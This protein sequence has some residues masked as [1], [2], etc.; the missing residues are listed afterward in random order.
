MKVSTDF[1]SICSQVS[2]HIAAANPISLNI[3]SVDQA[4][5]AREKA[6]YEEQS[7]SSGKPAQVIEKMVEGKIKKF[8]EENVLLEQTLVT[9]GKTKVLDLIATFNKANS[10]N[11]KLIS[12]GRFVL[13][14]NIKQ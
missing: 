10:A 4:L 13:G 14:Q 11:V 5:L 12:F 1:K 6:I 3:E 7:A 2:M 9:D 8:L